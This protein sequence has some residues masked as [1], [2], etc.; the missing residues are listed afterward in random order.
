MDTMGKLVKKHNNNLFRKKDT[1]KRTCNCCANNI[2]P[3]D[4]K[5]LSSNIVYSAE[6]LIGNN[7]Q[8]D[9]YFDICETEFKIRLDKY[10]SSF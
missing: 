4:G 8:G 1:N 2:C 6:D 5:C 9:K 10:K 7:Q 3:L